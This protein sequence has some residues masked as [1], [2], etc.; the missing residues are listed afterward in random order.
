MTAEVRSRQLSLSLR[1]ERSHEGVLLAPVQGA[2][3][4]RIGESIDAR[5]HVRLA[6]PG[7]RLLFEGTGEAAG[8]E[9]VGDMRLLGVEVAGG[10]GRPGGMG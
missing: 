5:V 6:E 2:M 3:D 8:L 7:G 1:V 10:A 9:A 4:R